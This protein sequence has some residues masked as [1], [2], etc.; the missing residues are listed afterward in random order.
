M[1]EAIN[2]P[3]HTISYYSDIVRTRGTHVFLSGFIG[4]RPD[5]SMG[6]D[7]SEQTELALQNM[8]AA[9]GAASSS[10]DN[11]AK[12]VVYLTKYEDYKEFNE[13]YKRHFGNM[14]PARTCI[15]VNLFPDFLIELD[16]YAVENEG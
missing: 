3:G 6:A 13:V 8:K 12:I 11:V 10:V 4:T 1:R 15:F 5:G 9:L 2:L 7:I 14:P 16:V